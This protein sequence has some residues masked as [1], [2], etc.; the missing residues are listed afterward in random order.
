MNYPAKSN[1]LDS[2]Y[3]RG[4]HGDH[5]V[6]EDYSRYGSLERNYIQQSGE[7][8]DD[9][10]P[11]RF[12]CKRDSMTDYRDVNPY[13]KD[14]QQHSVNRD[15]DISE[16]QTHGDI[17]GDLSH[18]YVGQQY[19]YEPYNYDPHATHPYM[20][21]SSGDPRQWYEGVTSPQGQRYEDAGGRDAPYYNHDHANYQHQGAPP[22]QPPVDGVGG[23]DPQSRTV[24]RYQGYVE[25]S[26]PFEMS[27][28]YKYSERLRR[29][30]NS[31][32]G[33]SVSSQGSNSQTP[34][35]GAPPSP[36]LTPRTIPH[37]SAGGQIPPHE[38][39]HSTPYVQTQSRSSRPSSPFSPPNALSDSTQ[40]SSYQPP[41]PSPAI[42]HSVRT[43]TATYNVG[44][45][46][47]ASPYHIQSPSYHSPQN[48]PRQLPYQPPQPM[49][50][51][52]L[53]DPNKTPTPQNRLV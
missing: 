20:N 1:S 10:T 6:A 41:T 40:Y 25:V 3:R 22:C 38:V 29:Q 52:A 51:E 27:D 30:R 14:D 23:G 44:G 33:Q 4:G 21:L 39:T 46:T 13:N 34:Y 24:T 16:E 31:D 15:Y 36:Y 5:S 9:L 37:P 35:R 50:C 19:S 49:T 12:G 28:F 26:K 45:S 42:I 17:Y 18:D 8:L 32:G 48:S 11:S 53:Q 7:Y 47:S 2:A 43:P